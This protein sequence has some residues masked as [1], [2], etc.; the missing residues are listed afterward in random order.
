MPT[1]NL[2][3]HRWTLALVTCIAS[4]NSLALAAETAD[5]RPSKPNVVEPL[6]DAAVDAKVGL[7]PSDSHGVAAPCN[8]C[9]KITC[10]CSK[11]KEA[12]TAAMK[13]AYKGVFYANDFS[14]LSDP[15]YDGPA[16][17]GD[18]LKGLCCNRVDVGGEVRVR[19]HSEKGFRGAGLSGLDD[20][21]LLTRL[22]LFANYRINEYF[23]FYGEYLYADSSG[24]F[25][26]P[27]IID[28]NHSEIQNLLL[29]TKL[30]ERLTFRVGRQEQ[31][32]GSQ[33]LISPLDWANT[34]RTFDGFK[35]LY[36]GDVWNVDGFF[37]RP[38]IPDVEK[39]DKVGD[40]IDFY[41]VYASR[42]DLRIGTVDGYYLGLNNRILDFNYHTIGGRV[43][44]KTRR[45]MMYE[46]EGGIQFGDNS[47]DFG[48]HTAGFF[49]GGLGRQLSICTRCGE[50]NPTLWFWYDW[51][52]GGND[53][54]AARGDNSFDHLF[55]LAHKYNGFMDL[56]GRRNLNDVNAQFI[57]PVFGSKRVK[58]LLWY[59]YFFLD[60]KTT[61]YNLGMA[62]FNPD[63]RAGDRDLG[64][65]L[66]L[67]FSIAVNPRNSML[68]G[69][70][71]FN[72]GKYFDTTA[73]IPNATPSRSNNDAQF[74]YTQYQMRF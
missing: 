12:A 69:Y 65:E 48:D 53:I 23:R 26:R 34:R 66:D 58:L 62:P 68:V 56:F 59:H 72:A 10:G 25:F 39:L 24:E 67:L 51:A 13:D 57:T 7:A 55:P 54:P 52:S 38:T 21:F 28:E 27:L 36:Q 1:G 9:P 32:Y 50:W 43:A 15:C 11:Q 16:F 20:D 30:T 44:G 70:S 22:R 19:Y 40:D 42:G 45:G 4:S 41:G 33:R 3:L 5:Q 31:M 47:P 63:N 61:P 49:T 18:S 35:L 6:N 29:D 17:P 74:F 73:G 71:F 64:H 37:L 46:L 60:Q 2:K 8:C 14:Y